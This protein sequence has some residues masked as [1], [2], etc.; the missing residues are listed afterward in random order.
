MIS[1][2]SGELR[3]ELFATFWAS[4]GLLKDQCVECH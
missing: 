1:P 3:E 2:S 4:T